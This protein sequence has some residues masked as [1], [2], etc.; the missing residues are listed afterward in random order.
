MKAKNLCVVLTWLILFVAVVVAGYGFYCN[1]L[2]LVVVTVIIG[3]VLILSLIFWQD[4]L[5]EK[6]DPLNFENRR[7]AL[8]YATRLK[9]GTKKDFI[10]T[11]GED[12]Y[13]TLLNRGYIHELRYSHTLDKSTRWE[14]TR[15]GQNYFDVLK[16]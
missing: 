7:K 6:S 10:A 8:D 5:Q 3:V 1:N 9:E 4:Y 15:L 11:Y 12:M 14:I 16:S 2:N 13:A